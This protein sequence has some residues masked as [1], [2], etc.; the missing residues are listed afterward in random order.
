M[1]AYVNPKQMTH[2]QDK[3]AFLI[4]HG[5]RM[6]RKEASEFDN[7]DTPFLPCVCL[8]NGMFYAVGI[9]YDAREVREFTDPN[10]TRPKT[11]FLVPKTV[12]YENSDLERY[13]PK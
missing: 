4:K 13:L 10:D 7:F 2:E 11:Y 6:S 9:A 1:G 8:D 3:I 12:L 5:K